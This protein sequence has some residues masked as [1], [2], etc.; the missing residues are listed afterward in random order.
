MKYFCENNKRRGSCYL[1]YQKGHWGGK[2]WLDNSIFM[3]DDVA[4][5][6]GIYDVFFETIKKFDPYSACPY[7][8]DHDIWKDIVEKATSRG[9]AIKQAVFEL[10]PWVEDNFKT[11]SVFTIITI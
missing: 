9:G 2:H 5:E 7:I 6:I 11:Q 10:S 3:D 4:V 8:I 1:E